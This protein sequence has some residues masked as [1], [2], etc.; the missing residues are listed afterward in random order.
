MSLKEEALWTEKYRPKT[1]K[2]TILPEELKKPFEKFI[3][4]RKIP[5]LL[6]SGT[7]G[8]G[9]TTVAR[10]MLEELK[11]DYIVINGSLEGRQIDTLRNDILNYAS[12]MSLRGSKRKYVIIDE[13]DY[14]N[15]TTVQPA[16]RNFMETFSKNCGFILTCNYKAKIIEPLQSRCSLIEFRIPKEEKAKLETEFF[17]RL[18]T[19]LKAEGVEYNNQALAQVINKYFPDYRRALNELQFYSANGKIDTG[20]LANFNKDSFKTLIDI[21]KAKPTELQKLIKW[22]NECDMDSTEIYRSFYE[23]GKEHFPPQALPVLILILAKYQYQ[24]A[25]A[26]DKQIN[27]CAC[28]LEIISTCPFR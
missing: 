15:P 14:L 4:D 13:A 8:V 10:A 12:S 1:I 16:M 21:M 9:K 28:L 7:S 24:D 20:I 6:L 25:F 23:H 3:K 27:T 22:V 17:K 18:V 26:L 5:N 19:I 2:D 11:A